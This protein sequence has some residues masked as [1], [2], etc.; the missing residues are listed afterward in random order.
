MAFPRQKQPGRRVSLVKLLP[1]SVA[2]LLVDKLRLDR[3]ATALLK[4]HPWDQIAEQG[5]M[6]IAII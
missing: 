5:D 4:M 6:Y 3:I 2:V 1:L